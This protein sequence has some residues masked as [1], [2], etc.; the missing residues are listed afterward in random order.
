[1]GELNHTLFFASSGSSLIDH[2]LTV[3]GQIFGPLVTMI[4]T[5][6][7]ILWRMFLLSFC[8][9]VMRATIA[10]FVT[11]IVQCRKIASLAFGAKLF[12][13][14]WMSLINTRSPKLGE[15]IGNGAP[16]TLLLYSYAACIDAQYQN[17]RFS[18]LWLNKF[19]ARCL[20]IPMYL[21]ANPL[22]FGSY[23]PVLDWKIPFAS[24]TFFNSWFRNSFPASEWKRIMLF[25]SPVMARTSIKT[26]SIFLAVSSPPLVHSPLTN[27]NLCPVVFSV[28]TT[29][30]R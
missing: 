10:P 3:S 18:P 14:P 19:V 7:L 8:G 11:A 5:L 1:M 6:G 15:F 12:S 17:V 9:S 27:G 20:M 23:P 4:F 26:S 16:S 2:V 22:L 24:K 28:T 29:T 30:S 21:S 13:S 25:F